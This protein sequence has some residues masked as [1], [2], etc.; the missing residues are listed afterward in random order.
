MYVAR[1]AP[2][3]F[4]TGPNSRAP[5]KQ[6]DHKH[7]SLP[8]PTFALRD[9]I[10]TRPSSLSLSLSLSPPPPRPYQLS[11]GHRRQQR[12]HPGTTRHI[13][14]RAQKRE[15]KNRSLPGKPPEAL[16]FHQSPGAG[17][18]VQQQQYT[19]REKGP[20]SDHGHEKKKG[21]RAHPRRRSLRGLVMIWRI[22]PD[23]ND[24]RS[25]CAQQQ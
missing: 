9:A 10:A 11:P 17:D 8:V 6:H 23:D 12:R 3:S 13:I 24:Y 14:P 19:K 5:P 15:A 22:P 2:L 7:D 25:V 20:H 21:S 1:A 16:L 4:P 18:D